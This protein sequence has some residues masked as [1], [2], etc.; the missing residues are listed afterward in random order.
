MQAIM[1]SSNSRQEQT[2]PQGKPKKASNVELKQINKTNDLSA[3]RDQAR[4]IEKR[5]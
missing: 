4:Q 2:A 3:T 1:G 5:A